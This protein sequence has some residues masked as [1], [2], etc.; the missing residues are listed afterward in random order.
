MNMLRVRDAA[1]KCAV[2]RSHLYQMVADGMMVPPV[3]I[4]KRTS[5]WIDEE[6]EAVLWARASGKQPT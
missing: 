1:K 2:S 3:N 4:A 5:A 6:I